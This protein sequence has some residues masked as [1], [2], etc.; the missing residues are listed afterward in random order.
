MLTTADYAAVESERY[1][2]FEDAEK[3]AND[4]NGNDLDGNA[5]A[6]VTKHHDGYGIRIIHD[7]TSATR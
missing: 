7:W 5:E 3:R 6:I 1:D 2:T 4:L